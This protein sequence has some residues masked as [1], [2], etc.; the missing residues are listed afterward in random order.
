MKFRQDPVG[1]MADVQEI[2]SQVKIKPKDQQSQRILW[3]D[4]ESSEIKVMIWQ[5]MTFGVFC[6][7]KYAQAIK[8]VN[9]RK[10]A[11]K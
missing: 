7:P 9:A 4:H 5:F 1:V 6:S 8:N 11:D 2:F 3:R 10:Y